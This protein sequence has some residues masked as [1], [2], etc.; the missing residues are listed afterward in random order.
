[1]GKANAGNGH[2]KTKP[3]SVLET[4]ALVLI[5]EMNESVEEGSVFFLE[6]N[7]LIMFATHIN[8]LLGETVRL[9]LTID[10]ISRH[11]N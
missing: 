1:M 2:N 4:N 11:R 10:S 5:Q 3:E 7:E 6:G 8:Y 9:R